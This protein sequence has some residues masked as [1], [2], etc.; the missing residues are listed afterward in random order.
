MRFAHRP[1]PL[2]AR[3]EHAA[4]RTR[5][6]RPVALRGH[7]QLRCRKSARVWLLLSTAEAIIV[8]MRRMVRQVPLQLASP[9]APGD[10]FL[11]VAIYHLREH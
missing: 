10:V 9:G 11:A 3:S 7:L 8:A 2:Y 1:L 4:L 5:C 6:S